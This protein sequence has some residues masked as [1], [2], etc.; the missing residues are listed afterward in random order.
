MKSYL[1]F[2]LCAAAVLAVASPAGATL[3][4]YD[5]FNYSAT[6]NINGV[7]SWID[8]GGVVGVSATGLNYTGLA[9]E[10]GSA[11][12][13][14]PQTGNIGSAV[15]THAYQLVGTALQDLFKSTDSTW[16]IS[17]LRGHT[18]DGLGNR[19]NIYINM[20]DGAGAKTTEGINLGTNSPDYQMSDIGGGEGNGA[21]A[22]NPV[23]TSLVVMRVRMLVGDDEITGIVNPDLIGGGDLDPGD[24][25]SAPA[26]YGEVSA[27]AGE[28]ID[29]L[30]ISIGQWSI[31]TLGDKTLL[32]EIRIGTT[33]ADVIPVPEPATLIVL[34]LGL[35][36]VLLRRRKG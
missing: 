15:G 27:T 24:F 17:Y 12:K 16:Y 34:S 9:T 8:S 26:A 6:N 11:I 33:L 30:G 14:L 36:P 10:G 2:V 7:G 19:A 18:E 35:V 21:A 4:F 13:K 23:G 25:D 28:N 1:S 29:W 32:D 5:G 20:H 3:V 22:T 31:N